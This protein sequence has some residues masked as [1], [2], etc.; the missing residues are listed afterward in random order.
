MPKPGPRTT[1]RY[2]DDFKATAVRLSQLPGVSVQ[3][4]AASL[5]RNAC[6]MG[7]RKLPRQ[8]DSSKVEFLAAS[9]LASAGVMSLSA[10]CGRSS[11][12][13]IIHQ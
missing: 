9:N 8:G 1:Y 6:E 3:D 2:T 10:S 11:L 4:V 13:S 5:V 12:Y 7:S